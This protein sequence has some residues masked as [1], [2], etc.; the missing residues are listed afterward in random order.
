MTQFDIVT[1]AVVL[2]VIV[3]GFWIISRMI[4]GRRLFKRD[5]PPLIHTRSLSD[6]SDDLKRNVEME[7][8]DNTY[9]G[10]IFA[11]DRAVVLL[12]C[13][14]RENPRWFGRDGIYSKDFL[15]HLKSLLASIHTK[16]ASDPRIAKIEEKLKKVVAEYEVWVRKA[17]Y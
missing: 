12:C 9:L 3:G 5:Q 1:I 10:F 17:K 2:I 7:I 8:G 4:K 14:S 16:G 11:V 15:R 6:F 13:M